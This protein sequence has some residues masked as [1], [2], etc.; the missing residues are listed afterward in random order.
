[1]DAGLGRHEQ[2]TGPHEQVC[3]RLSAAHCGACLCSSCP[4]QYETVCGAQ[5]CCSC[6]WSKTACW[7]PI[8]HQHAVQELEGQCRQLREE[9]ATVVGQDNMMQAS[10]CNGV[11]APADDLMPGMP[12]NAVVCRPWTSLRATTHWRRPALAMLWTSELNVGAVTPAGPVAA[13]LDVS[14]SERRCVEI[15]PVM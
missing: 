7:S 15:L 5:P 9:L 13:K 1:M 2:H 8:H 11:Q 3:V 14:A 12:V 10:T 6:T 4:C